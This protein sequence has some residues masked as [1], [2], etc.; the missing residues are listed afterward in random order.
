MNKKKKASLKFLQEHSVTWGKNRLNDIRATTEDLFMRKYFNDYPE[1]V[2]ENM[3]SIF[4]MYVESILVLLEPFDLEEDLILD[5][6]NN[7]VMEFSIF[8]EDDEAIFQ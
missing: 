7:F 3:V 4:V 2:R 6:A 5:W 8:N 1:D